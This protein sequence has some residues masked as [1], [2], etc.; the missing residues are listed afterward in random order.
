MRSMIRSVT[1]LR[2]MIVAGGAVLAL[3]GCISLGG[4]EP[5]PTGGDEGW[6]RKDVRGAVDEVDVSARRVT[7][8]DGGGELSTYPY[9]TETV[10]YFEGTEAD[11]RTLDRGEEVVLHLRRDEEGE[12]YVDWIE[13]ID[14]DARPA[15]DD[16]PAVIG[17]EVSGE[18]ERVLPSSRELVIDTDE[19]RVRL[20]YDPDTPVYYQGREY[21][22]DNLEPGDLITADVTEAQYGGLIASSIEVDTSVQDRGGRTDDGDVS[23]DHVRLS[24]AVLWV[25]AREGAFGMDVRGEQVRVVLPF[26]ATQDARRTFDRLRRGQRVEV[27]GVQLERGVVEL[28]RFD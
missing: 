1:G 15:D 25:D 13:L 14:E 2:T 7:V 16:E 12:P 10:V 22:V 5:A 4:G 28:D 20:G 8:R 19:G 17:D 3:T 26:N 24:G 9:S 11:P 23:V 6:Y 18:V 27:V 21:R